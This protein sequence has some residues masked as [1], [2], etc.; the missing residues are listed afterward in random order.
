MP[1]LS[2]SARKMHSCLLFSVC[3]A[4][5]RVK[6][7]LMLNACSMLFS[8]C[9]VD[10]TVFT[11]FVYGTQEKGRHRQRE[12]ERESAKKL[13][14]W[15]L[16]IYNHQHSDSLLHSFSSRPNGSHLGRKC[17]LICAT[18]MQPDFSKAIESKFQHT[19]SSNCEQ[20]AN[21]VECRCCPCVCAFSF[22]FSQRRNESFAIRFV[23]SNHG[24]WCMLMC[25]FFLNNGYLFIVFLLRTKQNRNQKVKM[26]TFMLLG[27][28]TVKSVRHCEATKMPCTWRKKEN[29]LGNV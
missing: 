5:C 18:K 13:R 26:L 15:N 4:M 24:H 8:F 10:H 2:I 9:F 22:P 6:A 20:C 16:D 14:E 25:C 12:R 23:S 1:F 28:V 27:I 21:A 11:L 29:V 3:F 7:L 17:T 19:K